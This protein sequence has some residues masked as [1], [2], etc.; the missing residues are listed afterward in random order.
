MS[1]QGSRAVGTTPVGQMEGAGVA[2]APPVPAERSMSGVD[3]S[4]SDQ[5]R[6][7]LNK[8]PGPSH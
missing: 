6:A 1:Q 5:A 3:H 8:R 2:G 7:L 4:R